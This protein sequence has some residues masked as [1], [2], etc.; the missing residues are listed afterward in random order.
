MWRGLE[1]R[2]RSQVKVVVEAYFV[3]ECLAFAVEIGIKWPSVSL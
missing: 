3:G 1:S 2:Q